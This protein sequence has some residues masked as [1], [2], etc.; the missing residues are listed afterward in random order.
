M[1]GRRQQKAAVL[2]LAG[3]VLGLGA[4]WYWQ[5]GEPEPAPSLVK[6]AVLPVSVPRKLDPPPMSPPAG[7]ELPPVKKG[8]TT[9]SPDPEQPP[10]PIE[11]QRGA[12]DIPGIQPLRPPANL[13]P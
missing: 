3:L 9:W 6:P 13:T 2:G 10:A 4:W 8:G 11:A 5:S 7:K 1:I 12:P